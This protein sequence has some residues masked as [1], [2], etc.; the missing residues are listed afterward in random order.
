MEAQSSHINIDIP[1]IANQ[2]RTEA[3]HISET[4]IWPKNKPFGDA[5]NHRGSTSIHGCIIMKPVIYR[6]VMCA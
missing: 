2:P 1:P 6:F 3:F 5:S 4:F